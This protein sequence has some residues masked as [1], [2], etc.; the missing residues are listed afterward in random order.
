MVP[1]GKR[2]I[3]I[4]FLLILLILLMLALFIPHNIAFAANPPGSGQPNQSCEDVGVRPGNAIHAAGSAFNPNGVAGT[5]YAGEQ[6]QNS[7][8]P[9][10]VSQYDVACFQVAHH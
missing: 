5:V 8:N 10:S 9:K 3:K 4:D 1:L 6:P 7:K 2:L